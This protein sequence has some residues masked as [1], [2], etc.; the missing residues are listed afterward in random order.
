MINKFS[1]AA[2]YKVDIQKSVA[3]LYINNEI[4]EKEYKNTIPFKIAL[5]STKYLEIDP[6]KEFKDLYAENIKHYSRKLK[7]IQRSGKIFHAPGL[8]EFILL[9]W[10]YYVKQS[11]DLM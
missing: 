2:G 7:K 3:F 4:I 1:K 9:K 5:Q 6:T 8:E 10:P 11:T